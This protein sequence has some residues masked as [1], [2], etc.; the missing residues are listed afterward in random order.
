MAEVWAEPTKQNGGKIKFVKIH[1]NPIGHWYF[2]SE[3]CT[4]NFEPCD[5]STLLGLKGCQIRDSQIRS[6]LRHNYIPDLD[7][8][9]L[10]KTR[11]VYYDFKTN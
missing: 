2:E 1:H 9:L 8:Q 5:W 7:C 6:Y 11:L 4:N 3:I 10:D